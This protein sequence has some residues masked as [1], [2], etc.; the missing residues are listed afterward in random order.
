LFIQ[1]PS[2]ITTLSMI[3]KVICN[4]RGT[5]DHRTLKITKCGYHNY[6]LDTKKLRRNVKNISMS[7]GIL[8]PNFSN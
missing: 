7:T 3:S 1:Y 5:S 8:K 6:F 2:L 4:G